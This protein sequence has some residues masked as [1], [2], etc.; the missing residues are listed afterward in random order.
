MRWSCAFSNLN[1]HKPESKENRLQQ[2]PDRARRGFGV[3]SVGMVPR[4]QK[5]RLVAEYEHGQVDGWPVPHVAEQ[6]AGNRR[7]RA[8]RVC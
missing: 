2:H 1:K 6:F 3:E 5:G 4:S 7:E 8:H